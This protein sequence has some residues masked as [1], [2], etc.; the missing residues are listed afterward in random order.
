MVEMRKETEGQVAGNP[1]LPKTRLIQRT[2][3]NINIKVET[4]FLSYGQG[5]E[6]GEQLEE[7]IEQLLVVPTEPKVSDKKFI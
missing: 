3:Q 1:S 2:L 6:I 4:N 5:E 7:D